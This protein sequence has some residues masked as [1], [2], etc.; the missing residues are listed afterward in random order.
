MIE[1]APRESSP[2]DITFLLERLEEVLG[3]GSGLPF[4]RRRLVDDE[5]CLAIVE[6]IRLSLP[7]EIRQARRVNTEREALLDEAESHAAQI[8]RAAEMEAQERVTEHHVAKRAETRAQEIISQAE[9]RVA[10]IRREADEYAYSVLMD[11]ETRLTGVMGTIRG[12]LQDLD[13]RTGQPR[14]LDEPDGD[15]DYLDR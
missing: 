10:Q 4:T 3:A 13:D 12:G 7:N 11:L 9:R 5:E 6:Q 15:R 1:P 14:A 8:I 2:S